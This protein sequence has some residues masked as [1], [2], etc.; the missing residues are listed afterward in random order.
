MRYNTHNL[1]TYDHYLNKQKEKNINILCGSLSYLNPTIDYDGFVLRVDEFLDTFKASHIIDFLPTGRVLCLGARCGE[2][3]QAFSELGYEA[4]GL[5]LVPA[6]PMVIQ[7]DFHNIKFKDG[8]FDM[9]YCN[10]LDHVF[11]LNKVLK[12]CNRVTSKIIFLHLGIKACLSEYET[13]SIDNV[14]E[15][16]NILKYNSLQKRIGDVARFSGEI[17]CE[18]I[19]EK[20]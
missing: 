1:S 12:E 20:P 9:I 4:V 15:I 3:V 14:E 18:L 11:D 5:D 19:L 16:L 13:I 2:E 17:N 7:G 10:C 8:S 6:H